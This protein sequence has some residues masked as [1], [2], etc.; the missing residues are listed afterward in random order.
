MKCHDLKQ[1]ID[2]Y[3]D[4]ELLVETNHDVHRHLENCRGC[5]EFIAESRELRARVRTAAKSLPDMKADAAF[6]ARLN[7]ELKRTALQPSFWERVIARPLVLGFGFA[8]LVLVSVAGILFLRTPREPLTANAIDQTN[9]IIESNKT[10]LI[11]AVK[12]AWNDLSADA[13]G[14]H[15]NCAVK[16][17]L[18]EA[19]ISLDEAAKKYCLINKD[20]DKTVYNSLK[21]T[22]D[23]R[24]D[25]RI[26][27][28]EAHSCLFHGRRFA[29]IVLKRNGKLI[30][31][32]VT[33][34]DLPSE[35]DG[36]VN[37]HFEGPLNAAGYGIG[38]HAFF[39]VSEMDESDNAAMAKQIYPAIRGHIVATG[40]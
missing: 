40:A 23:G 8:A 35:T 9:T 34:T 4:D 27:F 13:I 19:P 2:S 30:S 12:V 24:S 1:L 21:A 28:V 25:D 10:R 5:R 6:L 7:D 15:K 38:H 32:L 16:F 22:F 11:E 17:N 3:L 26:E 37:A 20:I 33:D 31:V 29:H 39:V 36:P 18:A 14:D